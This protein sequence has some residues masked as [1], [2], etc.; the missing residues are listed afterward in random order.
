[1]ATDLFEELLPNGN[2]IP[3]PS[4]RHRMFFEFLVISPSYFRAHTSS[5]QKILSQNMKEVPDFKNVVQMYSLC[6]NVFDTTFDEWWRNTGHKVIAADVIETPVIFKPDLNKSISY[7]TDL[8]RLILKRKNRLYSNNENKMQFV[9]NKIRDLTLNQRRELVEKKFNT[10]MHSL[11]FSK[12][13]KIP[14]WLGA[15][16]YRDN[17]VAYQKGKAFKDIEKSFVLEDG[18]K[19]SFKKIGRGSY[20]VEEVI[21]KHATSL[22]KNY[23]NE[24][25]NKAKR[26]LSM[27]MSKNL[28]EALYI[29]ENAAR[30]I[31]PSKEKIN[32]L[33]FDASSLNF[34][35]KEEG[36]NLFD[37]FIKMVKNN[38]ILITP[39]NKKQSKN[40]SDFKKDQEL[41]DAKINEEIS[42]D[43]NELV[44]ERALE[45]A[46]EM[47]RK[48]FT[49]R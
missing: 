11:Y 9:K 18:S 13:G 5:T 20:K 7:N 49:R 17:L 37:N 38:E 27:L 45:L 29:S 48:S 6:G 8:L 1:M 43:L 25:T 12:N 42:K 30:G 3:M 40:S 4:F 47:Y 10:I 28:S 23:A 36:K 34:I 41:L 44:E 33:K 24:S 15:Y 19:G 46:R 21:V 31:F 35:F 14:N 2:R 32:C 22:K 26:Y 39:I 16:H